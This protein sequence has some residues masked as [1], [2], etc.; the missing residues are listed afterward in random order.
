MLY[1]AHYTDSSM[2]IYNEGSFIYI[3]GPLGSTKISIF[4]YSTLSVFTVGYSIILLRKTIFS[5]SCNFFL[6]KYLQLIG[7]VFTSLNYGYGL[8][9][10][11]KGR[12]VRLSYSNL[13]F[14]FKLGYSKRIPYFIGLETVSSKKRKNYMSIRSINY[15]SLSS[16][17]HHISLFRMVDP[18]NYSGI[19]IREG[20]FKFSN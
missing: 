6:Q 4:K 10:S 16:T 13:L 19:T 18:Y 15:N 12:R 5:L 2:F 7:T 9:F 3:I 20:L 1:N 14:F 17:I 11:P 8:R